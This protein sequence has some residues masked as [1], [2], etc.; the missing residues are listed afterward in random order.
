V[1]VQ[2]ENFKW[3]DVSAPHS[4]SRAQIFTI[5]S[6]RYPLRHSLICEAK[7]WS[8]TISGPVHKNRKEKHGI[9][10]PGPS[11]EVTCITFTYSN[12]KNLI[13]WSH[14]GQYSEHFITGSPATDKS[15]HRSAVEG[16][17]S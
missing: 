9:K 15:E 5:L 4:H 6:P 14:L 13:T 7:T 17:R 8:L 11:L 1:L 16:G 2:G 3:A 10:V 12:G